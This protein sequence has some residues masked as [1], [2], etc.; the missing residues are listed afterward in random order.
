MWFVLFS[1]CYIKL[2]GITD[3]YPTVSAGWNVL[4]RAPSFSCYQSGISFIILRRKLQKKQYP[5]SRIW[6]LLHKLLLTVELL[7]CMSS[8]PC[9]EGFSFST[10]SRNRVSFP[11][12]LPYS[13]IHQDLSWVW[14]FRLLSTLFKV[15]ELLNLL[16]DLGHSR[17]VHY[18][19]WDVLFEK[20]LTFSNFHSALYEFLSRWC[21]GLFWLLSD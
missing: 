18:I 21:I 15:K 1:R 5:F 7:T 2:E 16:F 12:S 17:K 20:S 13:N 9:S 11:L 3:P 8:F 4:W 19:Y 14:T 10:W 6:K